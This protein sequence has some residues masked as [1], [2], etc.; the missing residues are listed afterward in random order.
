MSEQEQSQKT[1]DPTPKKLLD[2]AKKG[3]VLQSRELGTALVV[4]AGAAW[5]ALAGPAMV[6]SLETMVTDGLSFGAA[7]LKDFDPASAGFRLLAI[8]AVPLVI[9]F[10][11]TTLA[12]I[13][14][15]A[16][17]GS[18]GFRGGAMGFKPNKMNPMS[19]LKRMFGSHGLI[20]LIKSIA[21][22][23]LIGSIGGWL[24]VSELPRMI[25]LGA[26]DTR[27]AI[28]D[29]GGT[30]L[31][32]VLLMAGALALIALI[33]VPVQRMQRIRKLRMTKQEVKDEH[34]QSEGSPELKGQIRA[35][36]REIAKGSARKAVSEATV[37][38]TN[39]THFAVALRYNQE[40]DAA[41]IVLARGRGVTAEAIR[42]LA[43]ELDVP[44][45]S[46]PELARAIYYTTRAGH[47]VREDLYL[48]VATVLAF[49]FNLE[50]ARAAGHSQP[51][52]EVP[53]DARFDTDGR[54]QP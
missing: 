23:L 25:G 36:Q 46:Y 30:F 14:G 41:P 28:H 45:L 35:K 37:I 34:K 53:P 1:E 6:G 44:M 12:A 54:R 26:R 47:F 8:I 42:E 16:M 32:G 33:D 9:L 27:A 18:L 11:V 39:P 5:M 21:K 19:G 31:F 29:I 40:S 17:M 22:V 48:A 49:V 10:A 7:D 20:E 2:A 51:S 13:A 43:A 24:M 4:V 15:P 52:I 38:L 3:D 50:T